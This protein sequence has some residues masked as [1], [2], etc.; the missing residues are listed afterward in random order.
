MKLTIV[1]A[2][3]TKKNSGIIT[4]RGRYPRIL[5]SAAF[6]AWNRIAQLQLAAVRAAIKNNGYASMLPYAEPVNVRALFYRER[7][8]GDAVGYYQALGDALQEGLIVENDRLIVSWDGSR[9][10]KDKDNP[11]IEIEI[12]EAND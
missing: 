2:P 6:S 1:A 7:L 9:M 12:T 8:T 11:R 4:T 5:P 3:R 10:L